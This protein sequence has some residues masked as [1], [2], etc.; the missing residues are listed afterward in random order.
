MAAK[1]AQ[2]R[3]DKDDGKVIPGWGGDRKTKDRKSG[4]Q[5]RNTNMKRSETTEYT[6]ARLAR[7]GHDELLDAIEA[8]EMSVNAAAIQA[9]YRKVKTPLQQLLHWWGKASDEEREDFLNRKDDIDGR[10]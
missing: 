3:A 5:V 7:D 6:L 9:G 10:K 4:D 1:V 2:A 8:G